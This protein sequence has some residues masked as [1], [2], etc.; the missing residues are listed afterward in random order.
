MTTNSEMKLRD[1]GY[2]EDVIQ[3]SVR[4]ETRGLF[5]MEPSAHLVERTVERCRNLLRQMPPEKT[6][7]TQEKNFDFATDAL[8]GRVFAFQK[9]G[10]DLSQAL[11]AFPIAADARPGIIRMDRLPA[12]CLATATFARKERLRPLMMVD[13]HNVLNPAWWDFD[14][15]LRAVRAACRVVNTIA[16]ENGAPSSAVLMVLRPDIG[17]YTQDDFITI[18]KLVGSSKS[19]IWMIP[20]EEAGEYQDQDIIVLGQERVLS[21]RGDFASPGDA[22]DAFHQLDNFSIATKVRGNIEQATRQAV[23]LKSFKSEM[24]RWEDARA[25]VE[26]VIARRLALKPIIVARA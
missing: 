10:A 13:N 23:E 18:G 8:A 22:F 15:G 4:A 9:A 2:P 3:E 11:N 16:Q 7:S 19:D 24:R 12:D 5:D 20:Y 1:L 26:N 21:L 6:F 14:S 25:L 17:T